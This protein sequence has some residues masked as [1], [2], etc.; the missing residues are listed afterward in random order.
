MSPTPDAWKASN[1]CYGTGLTLEI[2]CK[3]LAAAEKEAQKHGVPLTI[4]ISD[5]GGNLLALHRMDNAILM[6]IQIA[7]DKA[8]TSVFGKQQTWQWSEPFRQGA[9]V[10]L[11]LHERWITFPGGFPVIKD[12]I[13]LGGLGVSGGTVED[14]YAARSALK[15]GGFSLKEVEEALAKYGAGEPKGK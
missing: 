2:A 11:F 7:M 8:L 13:L 1:I 14:L 6:S 5:A 10:P 3:M 9:M 15:A 12:G 4:A